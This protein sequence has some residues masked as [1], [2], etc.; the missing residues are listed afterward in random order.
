MRGAAPATALGLAPASLRIDWSGAGDRLLKVAAVLVAAWLVYRLIV[1][2]TRRIERSVVEGGTGGL[3]AREQRGRTLAQIVRNGST[4]ALAVLAGVACLTVFVPNASAPLAAAV[5]VLGLAL[6]FGAQGLVR[7]LIAGFVM[8]LEG[9]YQIG[10][11]I[12]INESTAGQVERVTLRVV[13]LRDVHGVLHTIPNGQINQVSNL[14]KGWSRAVLELGVAY[15]EDVDRVM[16]VLADVGR[17]LWEDPEWRSRLVEEPVVPGV[18]RFEDSAVVIRFM[19]KTP[20][21]KQ[22]EVARELRRR[23]K[24]RFDAEG[25]EIPFPHRTLYWGRGQAPGSEVP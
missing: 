8:L 14:T 9:Q 15:G 1:V 7:D 13:V 21:L 20:P 25:I 23:V 11:V 5:G 6:S 10:D 22:W 16:E 4:V 12:R 19:A 2:L 18:E 24:K 17:G 3:S